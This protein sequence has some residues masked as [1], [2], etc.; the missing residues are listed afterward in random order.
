VRSLSAK[1]WSKGVA[2]EGCIACQKQCD[3]ADD[4]GADEPGWFPPTELLASAANP[5]LIVRLE[6][7]HGLRRMDHLASCC[8]AACS[9]SNDEY[10]YCMT[11][12]TSTSTSG[13]A[14][15]HDMT[16]MI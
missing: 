5:D 2:R 7:Y 6:H 3:L 11:T 8:S 15:T 12:S 14:N 16:M 1:H 9:S 4:S 10:Y 13:E